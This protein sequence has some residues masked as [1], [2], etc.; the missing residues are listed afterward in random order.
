MIGDVGS[1][2]SD[3]MPAPSAST[4][5]DFDAS[6][7]P[8]IPEDQPQPVDDSHPIQL[9]PVAAD[10]PEGQE[11]QRELLADMTQ[12]FNSWLQWRRPLEALWGEIYAMYM[13]VI[14]GQKAFTRA[15]VFVP[16]AFQIIE[17]AVPKLLNVI[18][19]N[20]PFFE[21][22]PEKPDEEVQVPPP[23]APGMPPTPPPPP[24]PSSDWGVAKVV[25]R[26]LEYQFRMADFF[27]KFVDF[28]KQLMLYGTSYFY[29]Y[30]KVTRGWVTEKTPSRPPQSFFG[31]QMPTGPFGPEL[32]WQTTRTYKVIERR[33]EVD[34]LD[35]ADVYP[36]PEARNDQEGTGIFVVTRKPLSEVMEM[37]G[38]KFP[39]YAN[40]DKLKDTTP[41]KG[42]NYMQPLVKVERRALRGIPVLAPGSQNDN[43]VELITFWGR[44]DLD[45]DGIR[46]EV[47]IVVANRSVVLKCGPNPFEHGKRPVL[48]TVLFPVP[49]EWYGIGMIEPVMPLISE[50]NTLRNQALDVNNL[51]I[52]RMWKVNSLADIDLDTLI[53]VPNGVVLTDSMD[54][55]IPLEQQELPV[56]AFQTLATIQTDIENT[57]APRSVQGTPDGGTL[58]RTARGAQLIIG[59]ALEKFGMAAKLVEMGT[60]HRVLEMFHQLNLQFITDD[61]V[62]TPDGYY[63]SVFDE[64]IPPEK[65]R[66]K[67]KFKML[68]VS[69][70]ITKEAKIN[71][72]MAFLNLFKGVPGIDLLG[73]AKVMWGLMDAPENADK[74]IAAAPFPQTM[75]SMTST[76]GVPGSN[77]QSTSNQVAAN[78]ASSP[79][80][81]PG[82]RSV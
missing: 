31:L 74:I 3:G 50:L 21:V 43:L 65:L 26:I 68:G 40:G 19:G 59:Q 18:L 7:V 38:G 16:V 80:A 73:A 4:E 75:V 12:T 42:T 64:R 10:S 2:L 11:K 14:R 72:L 9:G 62:W 22:Q 37:C 6:A 51:I 70:T 44:R 55:I 58:G 52:N 32:Q 46:E 13:E 79:A 53:S 33:P 57:T 24:D 45:G 78:G 77:G 30:W 60:V 82:L 15:R 23:P 81:Q 69:D 29:V 61:T 34:V 35:I 63:Q 36:D 49:M 27:V 8:N 5:T 47:M 41:S 66:A 20:S 67:L 28:S 54:G 1:N 56:S 39:V 48:R 25:Q 76:P 17:A 71:Q